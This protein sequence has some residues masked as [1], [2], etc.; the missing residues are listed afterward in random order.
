MVNQLPGSPFHIGELTIQERVGV[1]EKID[2]WGRKGIRSVMP[3][4]H[5]EF[6]KLLPTFFV[7]L[8]DDDGQ[9]WAS[10]LAGRPGFVSSPSATELLISAWPTQEDPIFS[11]LRDNSAIGGLGIQFHTR[12]RNRVNGRVRAS[13]SRHEFRLEVSQSFGNCAQYIQARAPEARLWEDRMDSRSNPARLQSDRIEAAWAAL[14]SQ[15]DTFF[16]ASRYD[17]CINAHWD[18]LDVSHRG[19]PA[20]FVEI[21]DD[22]TVVFPDYKGNFFFNTLGNIVEDPRCSLLFLDFEW[23]DTLQLAGTANVIWDVPQNEA[24][25]R[26]AQRLVSFKVEKGIHRKGVIP[27]AWEFLEMAPQLKSA[28]T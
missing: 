4:Q 11:C 23:G 5:R 2:A 8:A 12:R 14:I 19:G 9:P 15:A 22:R 24:R 21:V 10:V 7:A 17:D 20:G 27:Y 26:L 18:G 25:W 28:E 16:I 3:E 6:F 13:N 1:R